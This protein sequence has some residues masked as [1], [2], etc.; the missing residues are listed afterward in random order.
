MKNRACFG[1]P[2]ITLREKRAGQLSPDRVHDYPV[3]RQFVHEALGVACPYIDLADYD[4]VLRV[5]GRWGFALEVIYK[6]EEVG[7]GELD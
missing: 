2:C 5:A 4:A 3:F 6:E 1:M 7:H